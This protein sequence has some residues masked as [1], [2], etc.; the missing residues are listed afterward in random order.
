MGQY[1][2]THTKTAAC[3]TLYMLCCF[4]TLPRFLSPSLF[5]PHAH[6][7]NVF[8]NIIVNEMRKNC[9]MT[10]KCISSV[11][12]FLCV[13]TS[14]NTHMHA[15]HITGTGELKKLIPGVK[16]VIS[17][18]SGAHADIKIADGDTITIGKFKLDCRATP[19]HT[20]G[21]L[22]V[23]GIPPP[24]GS[25]R[26]YFVRRI[27]V[28]HLLSKNIR[29]LGPT[30]RVLYNTLFSREEIFA[31]SQF[32]IFSREDIFANILFTRKYLPAKISSRENNFSR[33][34]LLA[35]ISSRENIFLR[36]FPC[37]KY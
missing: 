21:M 16:S 6:I 10:F 11:Y 4:A 29:P 26:I 1:R 17:E 2:E 15:D 5:L 35:K 30:F 19:G 9:G 31:K 7:L 20:S 32:E 14:V 3:C 34:Y 27:K 23:W 13:C 33:K 8:F 18:A 36:F 37:R 28:T 22:S 25:G 24:H 12:R